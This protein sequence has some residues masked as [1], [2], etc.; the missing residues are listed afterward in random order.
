M[1][2]LAEN[3]KAIIEFANRLKKLRMEKGL[4]Q[5]DLAKT[6]GVHPNHISRYER[7]QS[8]PNTRFLKALADCLNVST[9]YLYDGIEEDAAVA[10]FNDREFLEIFKEAEGLENEDKIVI[11]RFLKAFLNDARL[12][13]QYAS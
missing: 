10:D 6:L 5:T 9:D 2:A 4:S 11:K 13:K 12:K 8:R 7:G 1:K 3:N